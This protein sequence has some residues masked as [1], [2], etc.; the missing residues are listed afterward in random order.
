MFSPFAISS[1]K[2]SQSQVLAETTTTATEQKTASTSETAIKQT[3]TKATET[4]FNWILLVFGA[5]VLVGIIKAI[6]LN[7][8]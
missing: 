2:E 8:K 4:S 1:L 5:L 7:K 3:S 6:S